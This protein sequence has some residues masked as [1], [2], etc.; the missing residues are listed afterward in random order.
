MNIEQAKTISIA[1]LLD[2]LNFKPLKIKGKRATYLSPIRQEKTASFNVDT[3]KNV[4]F[5]H[6]VGI[7]GDIVSL[8]TF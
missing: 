2:K 7:G 6:G 3:E 1:E 5:D 4:W 8:L